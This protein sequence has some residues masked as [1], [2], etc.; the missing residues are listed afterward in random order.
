MQTTQST[1]HQPTP[2]GNFH[3][4]FNE[5]EARQDPSRTHQDTGL[6]PGE[7]AVKE[8]SGVNGKTITVTL[9]GE[10][11]GGAS[12]SIAFDGKTIKT[13]DAENVVEEL[14]Q[15]VEALDEKDK[16]RNAEART[17]QLC[18][19][20]EFQLGHADHGCLSAEFTAKCNFAT[21][22]SKPDIREVTLYH[23][24]Q[25][26]TID[27][28]KFEATYENPCVVAVGRGA[29]KEVFCTDVNNATILANEM[30]NAGGNIQ[31][32]LAVFQKDGG[33][34]L[35][36]SD[37]TGTAPS[38]ECPVKGLEF[39]SSPA[40][41]PDVKV[42]ID[43]AKNKSGHYVV[44]LAGDNG[45]TMTVVTNFD[46]PREFIEEIRQIDRK[47]SV[48]NLAEMLAE[49]M[50]DSTD[51]SYELAIFDSSTTPPG[52]TPDPIVAFSIRPE[53]ITQKWGGGGETPFATETERINYRCGALAEMASGW[54]LSSS[55]TLS[56]AAMETELN[57]HKTT[58]L[59]DFQRWNDATTTAATKV[60]FD[61]LFIK[62]DPA[63]TGT[64]ELSFKVAH[65]EQVFRGTLSDPNLASIPDPA[66]Q[67][68]AV[69]DEL[70]RIHDA[71]G[72]DADKLITELAKNATIVDRAE[73]DKDGVHI[74]ARGNLINWNT[75]KSIDQN[76]V[77]GLEY[78][79]LDVVPQ[80]TFINIAAGN[81]SSGAPTAT[82]IIMGSPH[83]P[84]ASF[85]L[86]ID[87]IPGNGTSGHSKMN[88][89]FDSALDRYEV[90][91]VDQSPTFSTIN[92]EIIF[93]V[94]SA[95][96]AAHV[97][98]LRDAFEKDVSEGASLNKHT[99]AV[100]GDCIADAEK[101][102]V[103]IGV[104]S[105]R[106]IELHKTATGTTLT[107][108]N[109]YGEVLCD[110]KID[111][112]RCREILDAVVPTLRAGPNADSVEL[113]LLR[114]FQSTPAH[115]EKLTI[116]G[117][118]GDRSLVLN[119]TP[120]GTTHTITGELHSGTT[121]VEWQRNTPLFCST[122]EIDKLFNAFGSGSDTVSNEE[123]LKVA[124]AA[125]TLADVTGIKV[126]GNDV[127]VSD[128]AGVAID[129][130]GF[131]T[132]I[133][134]NAGRGAAH[135]TEAEV[136]QR[137]GREIVQALTEPNAEDT[138][139]KIVEK[140][141]EKLLGNNGDRL[142]IQVPNGTGVNSVSVT[143]GAAG[144]AVIDLACNHG[145][146][147]SITGHYTLANFGGVG[148]P[149]RDVAR[150]FI[151]AYDSAR[152][153]T[154]IDAYLIELSTSKAATSGVDLTVER[155][156]GLFAVKDGQ[157]YVLK[158]N[159]IPGSRS[160]QARY[161]SIDPSGTNTVNEVTGVHN[162]LNSMAEALLAL[163]LGGIKRPERPYSGV[164]EADID[165]MFSN[166]GGKI[167]LDSD[168]APDGY[169]SI[170]LKYNNDGT[171][172]LELNG[173]SQKIKTA[174]TEEAALR[175]A[176][177]KEICRRTYRKPDEGLGALLDFTA[178]AGVQE[179]KLET[180][181]A[182]VEVNGYKR[183]VEISR[184]DQN[185]AMEITMHRVDGNN[186]ERVFSG[187]LNADQ[188]TSH[189]SH[190]KVVI[191]DLLDAR[192]YGGQQADSFGFD[193]KMVS[194]LCNHN[195]ILHNADLVIKAGI[196][197]G[198]Q[199]YGDTFVRIERAKGSDVSTVKISHAGRDIQDSTR[200]EEFRGLTQTGEYAQLQEAF[201][202]QGDNKLCIYEVR[203][204]GADKTFEKIVERIAKQG[205]YDPSGSR[206]SVSKML[207]GITANTGGFQNQNKGPLKIHQIWFTRGAPPPAG[208]ST[209]VQS[210]R[211]VK[212]EQV[213]IIPDDKE[214]QIFINGDLDQHRWGFH[215]NGHDYKVA[216]LFR[217]NSV[218][219]SQ[220]GI[221]AEFKRNDQGNFD[222][223]KAGFMFAMSGNEVDQKNTFNRLFQTV[224]EADE[225]GSLEREMLFRNC[226]PLRYVMGIQNNL[227][228][229]CNSANAQPGVASQ[230]RE[231]LIGD[232][233]LIE[234]RMHG[235]G[236]LGCNLIPIGYKPRGAQNSLIGRPNTIN[237]SGVSGRIHNKIV[238]LNKTGI[239]DA[240]GEALR[241]IKNTVNTVSELN[242]RLDQ[243]G[244]GIGNKIYEALMP[245][246]FQLTEEKLCV[247]K[248]VAGNYRQGA[249][250]RDKGTEIENVTIREVNVGSSSY[251]EAVLDVRVDPD[252][253]NQSSYTTQVKMRNERG[254]NFYEF[255]K[256]IFDEIE[257][258]E[259]KKLAR[260]MSRMV[261]QGFIFE[262]VGAGANVR[263]HNSITRPEEV[264]GSLSLLSTPE[265]A[266]R[267]QGSFFMYNNEM[268]FVRVNLDPDN[269]ATYN[270][271]RI[272]RH[273]YQTN[274]DLLNQSNAQKAADYRSYI[275]YQQAHTDPAMAIHDGFGVFVANSSDPAGNR[276]GGSNKGGY[277]RRQMCAADATVLSHRM[278]G[279]IN[280]GLKLEARNAVFWLNTGGVNDKG[281]DF[282]NIDVKDSIV[283]VTYVGV[284]N[285]NRPKPEFFNK[286]LAAFCD[287]FKAYGG[288]NGVELK[289]NSVDVDLEAVP[290]NFY[291]SNHRIDNLDFKTGKDGNDLFGLCL[292]NMK[293]DRCRIGHGGN[294]NECTG[295]N[296]TGCE[297]NRF[298][299]NV[300]GGA[301]FDSSNR[302]YGNNIGI[303]SLA[304]SSY[305][306]DLRG[307]SFGA[308]K[309]KGVDLNRVMNW[310]ERLKVLPLIQVKWSKNMF[311]PTADQLLTKRNMR[312]MSDPLKSWWED[313]FN[314]RRSHE[315][316][317]VSRE[318]VASVTD[319]LHKRTAKRD[320]NDK[321][322][323]MFGLDPNTN[324]YLLG[325]KLTQD[326]TSKVYRW[327]MFGNGVRPD[328]IYVEFD[329]N[330]HPATD[331]WCS[332][333]PNRFEVNADC[334]LRDLGTLGNT[335]R[336]Y[337]E[338]K[339]SNNDARP[340]VESILEGWHLHGYG[341]MYK[342]A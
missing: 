15:I 202:R 76:A 258:D 90:K 79:D 315:W 17:N 210:G 5:L 65:T 212:N 247:G 340:V 291:L 246:V 167:T 11:G 326:D 41:G 187:Q 27:G 37:S 242:A 150:Q 3:R 243:K 241:Y 211:M 88:L 99:I 234:Y 101:M 172:T 93:P 181:M 188:L 67:R 333:L 131:K 86:D 251:F 109:N 221:E 265:G 168:Y 204:T 13:I 321:S 50:D 248:N 6:A 82:D 94:G 196:V 22:G 310:D 236:E 160:V 276:M 219:R 215:N 10:A 289:N 44:T 89:S 80:Q 214:F 111:S 1:S 311:H 282:S 199:L 62:I 227:M 165:E 29:N 38:P 253:P 292:S 125:F 122:G 57:Q 130:G 153:G 171:L 305:S 75:E 116:R 155:S 244:P 195:F 308:I 220:L 332:G 161:D 201:N 7:T 190:Q 102:K 194:V 25:N 152:S 19:V 263:I 342:N 183:I 173:G 129:F 309:F 156:T 272:Y 36:L 278:M 191:K 135:L 112:A 163:D 81:L 14:P 95:A 157:P 33:I 301:G 147:D 240:S 279:A 328:R 283:A 71:T 54:L 92:D 60:A 266:D 226:T 216:D 233:G 121:V 170:E 43:V 83:S 218:L 180:T 61:N 327:G 207:S 312:L 249:S 78:T 277:P 56:K 105:D 32:L 295:L 69:I 58:T 254:L 262:E 91:L 303:L 143:R 256:A 337:A 140:G 72:G 231:Q 107:V 127:V 166:K 285:P 313:H 189:Y 174:L 148:F 42:D 200:S 45:Y 87:R 162:S 259:D 252:D 203:N 341:A 286:F 206:E 178:N 128:P 294:L 2:T 175:E 48:H 85:S 12:A 330:Q 138:H 97:T 224:N 46:D 320:E 339:I 209:T 239:R 9:T 106:S 184:K 335:M 52:S 238:Q 230:D 159:N 225:E 300:N 39:L 115:I 264:R 137:L 68:Q 53:G 113:A 145:G 316:S 217:E 325:L 290:A 280:D 126:N 151:L 70:V 222:E 34:A 100:L 296:V 23:R 28:N 336:D 193:A 318:R 228:Y 73:F 40:G 84:V 269:T 314:Y 257:L 338:G 235:K 142:T 108:R 245:Q 185:S 270:G 59:D 49:V 144:D 35:R 20:V 287:P 146:G 288:I 47:L 4:A 192:N 74:S 169:S 261:K 136:V 104:D 132:V 110:A 232:I 322:R 306:C 304:A 302:L 331:S 334:V 66:A 103:S 133:Q 186:R 134:A 158:V 164:T 141:V 16:I 120:A 63:T 139:R 18:G 299:L 198:Q 274:S 26:P 118:E 307:T 205:E 176:L 154:A 24:N 319:D 324:D 177:K 98:A 149:A 31:N 275:S 21:N 237:N 213:Y 51:R 179:V 8:Y 208:H 297:I 298:H 182:S 119:A 260:L 223:R 117:G 323:Y 229:D 267:L 114:H 255:R 64:Y 281:L 77:K 273:Y 317:N 268:D 123:L 96:A 30:V 55:S 293:I 329:R 197:N 124:G 284:A 250:Y 271:K